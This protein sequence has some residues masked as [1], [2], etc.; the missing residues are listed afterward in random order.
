MKP[1]LLVIFGVFCAVAAFLISADRLISLGIMDASLQSENELTAATA[2]LEILGIRGFLWVPAAFTMF[3]G[4][5]WGPIVTSRP[6]AALQSYDLNFPGTYE[7]A[8]KKVFDLSFIVLGV[9]LVLASGYMMLGNDLFSIDT[10]VWL[11]VEDGVLEYASAAILLIASCVALAVASRLDGHKRHRVFHLFLAV[12]FFLMCGE[13]IS[14]GQ[15]IFGFGTPDALKDLNA[16]EELNLHNMFGYLFDHLFIALF[17]IWGCVLP[18][19][20]A[21]FKSIRQIV[22]AIGLPVPSWGLAVMMLFVTLFQD[23]I[24]VPL[25][26]SVTALRPAELRELLSAGAFL[27]LMIQSWRHMVQRM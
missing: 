2:R 8:I 22:R 26:G 19:L 9:M 11:N 15:R 27:M 1:I 6:I 4:L 3:I 12:L 25:F 5:F 17:F 13:E 16:Q 24:V 21:M 7:A 10:L 18:M 14:W 23:Q 20:F